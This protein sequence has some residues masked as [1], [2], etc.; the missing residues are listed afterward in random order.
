MTW[1]KLGE[2]AKPTFRKEDFWKPPEAIVHK[3]GL[4]VLIWGEISD[5]RF[6]AHNPLLSGLMGSQVSV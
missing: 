5:G 1:D 3:T 2:V 6:G 4:K